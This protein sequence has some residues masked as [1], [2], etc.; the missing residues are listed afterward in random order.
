MSASTTGH[1]LNSPVLPHGYNA[2]ISFGRGNSCGGDTSPLHQITTGLSYLSTGCGG[3]N[4]TNAGG[5]IT[6]GTPAISGTTA[7]YDANQPLD[8]TMDVCA[9]DN[10]TSNVDQ[11]RLSWLGSTTTS[12]TPATFHSYYDVNKPLNLSSTQTT[13]RLPSTPP[14]S[15]NL[16]IIQEEIANNSIMTPTTTISSLAIPERS[17][18]LSCAAAV[19]ETTIT[20]NSTDQQSFHPQICLTDV[21]G[22]E[23]TLVSLNNG[24]KIGLSSNSD[25]SQYHSQQHYHAFGLPTR[26]TV[27]PCSNGQGISLMSLQGL[28]L[29]DPAPDMPSITRGIGRKTSMEHEQQHQHQQHPYMIPLKPTNITQ[30]KASVEVE[31]DDNRH[32]RGSDKSL[33]FSD[34]SLSNDSNN[35]LSPSQ[36]PSASSGFKSDSHSEAGDHTEAGHL[37]PDSITACDESVRRLTDDMCY[38]VL[39][40]N[41]CSEL[42][43]TRILEI[44]KKTLDSTMPP[45]GFTLHCEKGGTNAQQDSSG[46]PQRECGD[47]AAEDDTALVTDLVNLSKEN[48]CNSSKACLEIEST[49]IVENQQEKLHNR[50]T[51]YDSLGEEQVINTNDVNLSGEANFSSSVRTNLN[52]EYSG[53][54]QIEVQVCEGR[55]RDNQSTSKGIKLRRISGDQFEYGKLCQQLISTLNMQQVVG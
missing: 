24:Q 44:V 2:G 40:P 54:L 46:L 9:L 12:V 6:R 53:G 42:D 15:P 52:L 45:K 33:G 16:C 43:S 21:Q 26:P 27:S 17:L 38:E 48:N 41:E 51:K 19:T 14:T 31:L 50:R 25:Y 18:G 3:G 30:Y 37:T 39:L 7:L 47:S 23:I 5:S 8:L 32:R 20:N 35:L 13:A 29:T 1:F 22:S 36:E 49:V 55:N 11:Q 34:D 10:S 4:G 28:I